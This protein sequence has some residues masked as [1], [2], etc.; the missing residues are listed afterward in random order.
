LFACFPLK[1]TGAGAEPARV[2]AIGGKNRPGASG[3]FSSA[4]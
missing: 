2:V 4:L 1:I 3:E